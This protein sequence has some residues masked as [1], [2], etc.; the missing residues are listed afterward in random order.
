MP[1]GYIVLRQPWA[2]KAGGEGTH[3]PVEKS[4]GDVLQN[5]DISVFFVLTRI[6]ILHF[7]LF[8]IKVAEF[9]VET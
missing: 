5:E 9:R 8:Q 3:P 4:A 1:H 6:E 2:L 7:S